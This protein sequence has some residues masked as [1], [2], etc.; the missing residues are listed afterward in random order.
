MLAM[1]QRIADWKEEAEEIGKDKY[2]IYEAIG[3]V[4][5]EVE[6]KEAVGF[7]VYILLIRIPILHLSI[8]RKLPVFVFL[9]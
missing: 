6:K 8:L 3:S 4:V 1:S 5:A 9:K 7:V 2:P